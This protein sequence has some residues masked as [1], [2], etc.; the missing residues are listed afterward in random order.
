MSQPL[1]YVWQRIS[2]IQNRGR[3]F[4]EIRISESFPCIHFSLM[5]KIGGN[6]HSCHLV[7]TVSFF[8]FLDHSRNLQ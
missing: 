5:T 4:T 6:G 2:S 8:S 7:L 1:I 3:Q